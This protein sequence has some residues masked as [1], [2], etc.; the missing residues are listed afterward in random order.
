MSEVPANAVEEIPAAR[1][2]AWLQPLRRTRVQDRQALLCRAPSG[3]RAIVLHFG[4]DPKPWRPEA[5]WAVRSDAYA[6]LL[7]RLLCADDVPVRLEAAELPPWLRFNLGAGA[8]LGVLN[9]TS[10]VREFARVWLIPR[11]ARRLPR[12][13]PRRSVS[14]DW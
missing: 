11:I 14:L 1:V 13:A 6:R 12:R 5:V 4:G 3:E 10:R 8:L 2:A 9:Q 7:P